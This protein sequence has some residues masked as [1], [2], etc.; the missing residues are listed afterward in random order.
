MVIPFRFPQAVVDGSS[1][2]SINIF[3]LFLTTLVTVV[4]GDGLGISVDGRA[5]IGLQ[6]ERAPLDEPRCSDSF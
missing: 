4:I 5:V 3:S 1:G 2:Q 6:K